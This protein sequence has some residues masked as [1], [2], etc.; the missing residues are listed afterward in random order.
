MIFHLISVFVAA[1]AAVGCMI[2]VFRLIGR[3]PPKFL[4]PLIAAAAMFFVNIYAEYNWFPMTRDG[5]PETV[6]VVQTFETSAPWSPWSYKWPRIERF[7]AVDMS[8]IQ[9]NPKHPGYHVAETYLVQKG[10][11][12]MIIYHLFD[13]NKARIVDVSPNTE[14]DESG[15]PK[16]DNWQQLDTDHP[17]LATVCSK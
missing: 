15:L 8:S 4:T 3:K 11:D 12:T 2:L 14:F 17:M 9:K 1:I 13:C 16:E 6:K 5:L 10:L 7:T